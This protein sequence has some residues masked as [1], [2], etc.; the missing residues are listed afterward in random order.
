MSLGDTGA[1]NASAISC[2]FWLTLPCLALIVWMASLRLF[3]L[4]WPF[5]CEDCSTFPHLTPRA[6]LSLRGSH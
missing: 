2:A 3:C 5:T 1:F 4:P 6:W